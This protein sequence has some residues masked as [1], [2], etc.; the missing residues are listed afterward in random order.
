MAFITIIYKN[1]Y[2]YGQ[3]L[4]SLSL[5]DHFFSQ[6][7]PPVEVAV[8]IADGFPVLPVHLYC[9]CNIHSLPCLAC[10]LQ[11]HQYPH[12]WSIYLS[13]FPMPSSLTGTSPQRG[14]HGR[15]VSRSPCSGTLSQ[16]IPDLSHPLSLS[17][18]LPLLFIHFT[19][20]LPLTPLPSIVLSYT[21]FIKSHS[22]ILITCP[23][24]HSVFRFTHSTT[25]Q[26]IPT[27]VPLIP[28]LSPPHLDTPQA[29]CM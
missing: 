5:Y 19:G 25:L 9:L 26:S 24:H 18:T 10:I 6:E 28:N 3:C 7:I 12:W 8:A 11:S 22:F 21:L 17:N 27:A 16:Y 20:G 2:G 23:Y 29:P 1:T 14:G 15:V 4:P 13:I